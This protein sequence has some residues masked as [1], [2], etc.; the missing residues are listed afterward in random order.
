MG[1]FS[2]LAAE[3]I[4]PSGSE[5]GIL[6]LVILVGIAYGIVKLYQRIT[7]RW[8]EKSEGGGFVTSVRAA[9]GNYANFKGRATR[10][11]YWWFVLFSV[12]VQVA[13]S[14]INETLNNLVS[15]A[16][17]IP[18]IAVGVRRLH[19]SDRRGWWLLFPVVNLVLLLKKSDAGENRFGRPF[20]EVMPTARDTYPTE[21]PIWSPPPAA[22]T[23]NAPRAEPPSANV[24]SSHASVASGTQSSGLVGEEAMMSK[25]PQ[26]QFNYL[27]ALM[28]RGIME[29]NIDEPT[30]QVLMNQFLSRAKAVAD[31]KSS[32]IWKE[33][34][35]IG[36]D[37][38]SE[39]QR[40]SR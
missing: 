21:T 9:L 13:A 27:C 37:I 15:V 16:L 32:N 25:S 34:Q 35:I 38:R 26:E 39:I 1:M 40:L 11:E 29:S 30:K 17:L 14:I 33:L 8:R 3:E 10:S 2:I 18:G 4:A 24:A 19:D 23:A 22:N 6:W 20:G 28:M 31:D 36:Q 5:G 7:R 12:M